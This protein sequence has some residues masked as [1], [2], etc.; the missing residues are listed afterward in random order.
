MNKRLL[1]ASLISF[2][3]AL[4][5]GCSDRL[6][7]EDAAFSL[8]LGLDLDKENHLIVYTTT[9][10]FSRDV[11]KR[12]QEIEV[13][14]K[15]VRMS[16]QELDA[17]TAGA[18]LG[19]KTQ[20]LLVGKRILQHEG[21]FLLLEPFFRDSRNSVTMRVV[22]VDG[23]VS[24]IIYNNPKDKP[25]LPVFMAGL[26]DTKYKS[27]ETVRTTL[28]ELHRQMYEKGTTA[29]ISE[30]SIDKNVRLTG[31]TLLDAQGK[32]AD[33]LNMQETAFLHILKKS[34]KKS[35]SLTFA[36]PGKPKTGPFD[37]DR[38]A[39]EAHK[40][41]TKIKT[42][43]RQDKFQFD[44]HVTMAVALTEKLFAYDVRTKGAQLEKM[45]SEQTQKQIQQLIKKNQKHHI[46]AIGLGL[47]A[48]AH[49]YDQYKK[50]EDHWGDALATADVNVVVK[51]IITSMGP[52]K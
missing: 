18:I 7:L 16:R 40:I 26:I 29:S 41:K 3:L 37:T 39:V 27:S 25:M 36:I 5:P 11:K 44:I 46:D 8:A 31:T 23:P 17:Y 42:S 45:I 12:S 48:R 10:V 1:Y 24:D 9:S 13:K 2:A 30:I 34:V 22:A 35:A 19:R 15:T 51:A 38:I 14:T 21:W 50:V 20:V 28:Q 4:L 43:Y 33:S 49:E 47:Y 52:V 32:Y 6:D